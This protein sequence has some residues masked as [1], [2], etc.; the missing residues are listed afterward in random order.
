M[1]KPSYKRMYNTLLKDRLS[2]DDY[3]TQY[4]DWLNIKFLE[5]K[6]EE[7]VSQLLRITLRICEKGHEYQRVR[8]E[9]KEVASSQNTTVDHIRLA[10]D[11]PETIEW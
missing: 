10:V 5:E 1:T 11:Y 2:L 8:A 9:V 7:R 6:P 4:L 3:T